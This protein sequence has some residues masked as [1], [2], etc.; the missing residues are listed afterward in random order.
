M[1]RRVVSLAI[2]TAAFAGVLCLPVAAQEVAPD[3]LV[4][5]SIDEVLALIKADKNLA[6][7][8]K[9]LDVIEEKVLPHFNF[10]RMTRL[11]VG[12][13]WSQASDAQKEALTREFRTLLVR[14]Y[15]TSL[16]Q[17][18]NQTIDVRP[19]KVTAQDKDVVVKTLV[20]QPGGQPIPIDYGMERTD[21]GWKVYDVVVDGVS[22]VT[23]YRGSFNDQ[24]QKSGLDGLVKTLADRNHSSEPPK[25]PVKVELNKLPT[26]RRRR[27]WR[28]TVPFP[29]RACRACSPE[30]RPIPL[31]P[32]CP[33]ALPS[34]LPPSPKWTLPR[35]P[36]SSSGV[37]RLPGVARV[38]FS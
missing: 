35:L 6:G 3:A 24:I 27:Y 17:Y 37:A 12:R 1:I 29:S 9:L 23:T 21:S 31:I 33:T 10:A 36:C 28:S 22:L 26:R 30:A 7:G 38:W 13:N 11:A 14:T 34:I 20:N 19:T 2:A 4:R 5:K 8:Q 16:S 18:R 25:A 32:T 15:S